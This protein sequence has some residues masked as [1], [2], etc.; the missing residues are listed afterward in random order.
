MQTSVAVFLAF[1]VIYFAAVVM[2]FDVSLKA[3]GWTAQATSITAAVA[4]F[5]TMQSHKFSL[6]SASVLLL[7]LTIVSTIAAVAILLCVH[8]QQCQDTFP[9]HALVFSTGFL[10]GAAAYVA[11]LVGN[12]VG[13]PLWA[14]IVASIVFAPTYIAYIMPL[15]SKSIENLFYRAE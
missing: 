8:R 10:S 1:T 2:P 13:L 4:T 7:C 6:T 5:M 12:A 9:V 14:T 11:Y 15:I 3:L